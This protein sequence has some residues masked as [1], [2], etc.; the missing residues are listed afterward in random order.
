[1]RSPISGAAIASLLAVSV[2]YAQPTTIPLDPSIRTGRLSNGLTYYLLPNRLPEKRLWLMLHV[3]AGSL[4]EDD[5]QRGL[6]HFVEHMGFNGTRHFP[7]QSLIETLESFGMRF[8]ADLNAFTG[9]ERTAYMLQVPTDR[10]GALDT[11]LLILRDWAGDVLFDSLEFE[12][13]RGVVFEEWRLGKGAEERMWEKQ[14]PIIYRGSKYAERDPIGDTAILLRAPL[15]AALRF[16]R[17]WY[18][19]ELMTLLAVG[20][21]DMAALEASIR[22]VFG[23]LRNPDNPRVRQRD[24]LPI[25]REA[26]IATASDPEAFFTRVTIQ[27]RIPHTPPR[28]L[29]DYRQQLV[30]QLAIE[31]IDQELEERLKQPDAPCRFVA[32]G[33][34]PT[35]GKRRNLSVDALFVADGKTEAALAMIA[36]EFERARRY[37]FTLSQ[38]DQARRA[39]LRR[40]ER[41]YDERNKRETERLLFALLQQVENGITPT[42]A[43]FRYGTAQ[44][45]LPT[46]TLDDIEAVKQQLLAPDGWI[47]IVSAAEKPDVAPPPTD[48]RIRAILD[49]I[50]SASLPP[51][52]DMPPPNALIE[53]LPQP[54]TVVSVRQRPSSG[55]TEWTLS[56]GIRVVL[57][58]TTNSDD[59]IH[60]RL[61]RSGGY[62]LADDADLPSARMA[63][64]VATECGAGAHTARDIERYLRGKV[65]TVSPRITEMQERIEGQ[66]S[67]KDVQTMFELLYLY[68]TAPRFDSTGFASF[69]S[70]TAALYGS[71]ANMPEQRYS[72]TIAWATVG[73]HPRR[74]PISAQMV[75]RVRLDR[76]AAFYRERFSDLGGATIVIVGRFDPDSIR[77]LVE[78]Y[79]ASLPTT[80]RPQNWRDRGIRYVR[81]TVR[82]IVRAGVEPK[83][84]VELRLLGSCP[85]W[86]LREEVAAD[87][88]EHILSRHV[89][90]IVREEMGASYSPGAG[91]SIVRRPELQPMVIMY[92]SCAPDSADD[93]IATMW[94][95]AD[96]LRVQPLDTLRF[97]Q[98]KE[99]LLREYQRNMQDD[100]QI[101]TWIA[102]A[103]WLGD[104][105]DERL[106]RYPDI[107]RSITPRDV[108]DIARRY[109]AR[110]RWVTGI[111]LPLTTEKTG[112]H[113]GKQ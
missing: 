25:Y 43:E 71:F 87:V 55:I 68:A 48:D 46:I 18:R 73:Y 54:G 84:L 19:P 85:K 89:F 101:L 47:V 109:I 57:K 37:R 2:L 107:V 21:A 23:D 58:P 78:R 44:Q 36:T 5:D 15:S 113:D 90:D 60:L 32:T 100:R 26:L 45:M 7:K 24:E 103:Y 98:G 31:I 35:N 62:S 83:S 10:P 56:N 63:G 111:M 77:P 28:T 39:L 59:A 41:D 69:R 64:E 102:D 96:S 9:Y 97:A 17:Q 51:Y 61:F 50:A 52:A 79:V 81:D 72:D 82:R 76:A 88:F 30:E 33:I 65:V 12:R 53:K 106:V 42:S 29:A 70:K 110:N 34:A 3:G 13:E 66:A 108:Q 80:R 93:I 16:Y 67:R 95:I 91:V 40:A 49:S 104:D 74:E 8:G 105:P 20:D 112:H 94:R 1:M 99:I 38:L 6:A 86:S 22:R 75:E 27:R 14:A 4:D 11:A 92:A